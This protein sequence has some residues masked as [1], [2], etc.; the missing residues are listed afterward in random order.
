M[1]VHVTLVVPSH[2]DSIINQV[3][4]LLKSTDSLESYTSYFYCRCMTL[5]VCLRSLNIK[6]YRID[7]FC[8]YSGT[9]NI[10]YIISRHNCMEPEVAVK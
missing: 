6:V 1:D 3:T 4:W 2:E 8:H 5:N 10:L 7:K 9:V